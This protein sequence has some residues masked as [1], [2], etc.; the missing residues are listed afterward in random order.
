MMSR[1]IIIPTIILGSFAAFAVF[2]PWLASYSFLAAAVLVG[3]I[4][5]AS[6]RWKELFIKAILA[7]VLFG[8]SFAVFSATFLFF[9]DTGTLFR[10]VFIIALAVAGCLG[11]FLILAFS[12]IKNAVILARRKTS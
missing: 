4:I 12:L 6:T 5:P 2:Q 7:A 10:Q 3:L 1:N 9:N 8:L 11:G